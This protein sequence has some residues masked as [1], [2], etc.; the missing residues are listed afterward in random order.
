MNLFSN[1]F[2]KKKNECPRCLG[3]GHVDLNDIKRLRKE[4]IWV[5][6]QCAYCNGQGKVASDLH[7]KISPDNA[8]LTTDLSS[9]E[10]RELLR[11]DS[12][13]LRLSAEYEKSISIF[14]EQIRYLHKEGRMD[15]N[16]ITSF[17]I[18]SRSGEE[19]PL[20]EKDELKK[21]IEKIIIHQEAS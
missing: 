2:N 10:R 20:Q 9:K 18:I 4:L 7:T 5:P 12:T 13:M 1:L 14:I 8:F 21:Y 15:A 16:T 11:G 19:V 3:K 6:G 17:L